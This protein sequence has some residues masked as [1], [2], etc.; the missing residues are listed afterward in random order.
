ME[1]KSVVKQKLEEV[2]KFRKSK[3]LINLSNI[4]NSM[5]LSCLINEQKDFCEIKLGEK[6]LFSALKSMPNNKT[7]GNDGQTKSFMKHFRTN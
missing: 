2:F 5:D 6:E 4:L 7:P 1:K 3:S